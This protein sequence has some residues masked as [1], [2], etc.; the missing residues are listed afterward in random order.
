MKSEA[1]DRPAPALEGDVGLVEQDACLIAVD[2][3]HAGNRVAGVLVVVEV[4]DGAVAGL[5]LACP[6]DGTGGTTS[7]ATPPPS[8]QEVERAGGL[9]DGWTDGR[10]DSGPGVDDQGA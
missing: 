5:S 3:R 8:K 1:T 2:E 4:C 7:F 9:H 6:D 10:V